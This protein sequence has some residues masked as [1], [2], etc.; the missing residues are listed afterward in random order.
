MSSLASELL[1]VSERCIQV[2]NWGGGGGYIAGDSAGASFANI[3]N[4]V[5]ISGPSTSI[6][7]CE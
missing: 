6:T 4:N 7:A 3:V 2:Y 5:F 1:A